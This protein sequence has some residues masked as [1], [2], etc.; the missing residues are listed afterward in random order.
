MLIIPERYPTMIIAIPVTGEKVSGPGEAEEILL[1]DTEKNYSVIGRFENPALTALN[2]RGIRMLQSVMSK[3]AT[4]I[5]VAHIG[6]HAFNF[7]NGKIKIYTAVGL[8]VEE[9]VSKFKAGS[10][11]ELKGELPE[12]THHH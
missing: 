1:L 11:S 5:I 12:D 8:S 4:S 10:L 9:A 3:N 7:A 6:S 2:A